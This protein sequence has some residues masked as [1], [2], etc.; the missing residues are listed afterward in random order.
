[1]IDQ[2]KSFYLPPLSL[3]ERDGVR[4]I[5]VTTFAEYS[6]F[7]LSP[8]ERAGVRDLDDATVAEYPHFPLS[9]AGERSGG[10]K[11]GGVRAGYSTSLRSHE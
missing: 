7:P 9:L 1:M 10:G 4:D 3:W 8:W 11:A 6:H 2:S 5:D